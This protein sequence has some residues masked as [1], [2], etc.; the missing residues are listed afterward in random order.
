MIALECWRD[1]NQSC[2]FVTDDKIMQRFE[3]SWVYD[4]T[5]KPPEKAATIEEL[6]E[7]M[8]LDRTS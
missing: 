7:K 6:A 5:D 3:G 1:Q 4:T 2:F 8:G